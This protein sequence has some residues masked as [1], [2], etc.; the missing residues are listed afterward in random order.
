MTRTYLPGEQEEPLLCLDPHYEDE[1]DQ[2]A[3]EGYDK[4]PAHDCQASLDALHHEQVEVGHPAHR[5]QALQEDGKFCH[6]NYQ[7]EDLIKAFIQ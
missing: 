5:L 1:A 6:K 2:E 4:D 3:E 7:W